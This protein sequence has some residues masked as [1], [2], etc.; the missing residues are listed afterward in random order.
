MRRREFLGALGGAA[1]WPL[2]AHAQKG[3]RSRRV[4]V[5][6]NYL[7]NHPEAQARVA[8][9]RTRMHEAGWIE[10]R[11][12]QIDFYWGAG[13]TARMRSAV[14]TLI[15]LSPHV[16]VSSGTPATKAV[17]QAS[18]SIPIVF[19]NVADPVGEG[20]VTSLAR[21]GGITTGFTN[22]E[23]A[24][25]GK[26][27]EVLHETAP[28]VNRFAVMQAA[29]NPSLDGF[30]REIENAATRLRVQVTAAPV[31]NASDIEHKIEVL[32]R[33]PNAGLIVLP[34]GLMISQRDLIVRLVAQHQL[35]TIY[36]EH[37]FASI[38]GLISYSYDAAAQFGQAASYVDRILKGT[39]PGE[40]PVQGPTRF[41]LAINLKTAKALGITVP[42]KLLGTADKLIE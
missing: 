17:Q 9:F 12:I 13:G 10:G 18:S 4:A 34:D 16:I 8:A 37:V 32:A 14:A 11:N 30:M 31:R 35:P 40:L 20:I 28:K 36:S 23:Y 38:G 26:W 7:V 3:E 6:M 41:E 15:G 39:M 29:N 25:G 2:A 27:L 19:A 21:P 22:Y 1:A 33:E 24:I 42:D 5:L